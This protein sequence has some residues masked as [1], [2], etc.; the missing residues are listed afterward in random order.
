MKTIKVTVII[1][2]LTDAYGDVTTKVVGDYG[3]TVNF[4]GIGKD[5]EWHGYDAYEGIHAYGWAE[6]RGMKVDCF[7]KEITLNLPD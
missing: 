7:E 5:G 1:Y 6:E 2:T 4:G 3:D